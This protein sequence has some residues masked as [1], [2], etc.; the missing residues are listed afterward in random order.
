MQGTGRYEVFVKS[1][2]G[3][4]EDFRVGSLQ[5]STQQRQCLSLP[6]SQE[7][8]GKFEKSVKILNE[9]LPQFKARLVCSH[10][11]KARCQ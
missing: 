11:E 8:F 6:L 9:E 10:S 2:S 7:K 5:F 3:K 1:A 4:K